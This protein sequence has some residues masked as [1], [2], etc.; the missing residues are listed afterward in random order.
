MPRTVCRHAARSAAFVLVLSVVVGCDRP[1]PPAAKPPELPKPNEPSAAEKPTTNPRARRSVL[2]AFDLDPKPLAFL[3]LTGQLDG[4]LEPC[5]C[6][7]GQKG[8]LARRLDLIGRLEKRGTPI[9]KFDLGSLIQI[10]ANARGG[11]EE[12]KIKFGVAIKAL[13][14]M[15]YDAL[16]LSATDLKVGVDNALG[17]FVNHGERPKV[18]AANVFAEGN[19]DKVFAKS[20]RLTAGPLKIGVVGVL[21]PAAL[22]ILRDDPGKASLTVKEPLEVLGGILKDLEKDTDFQVLLV[23]ERPPDSL[24]LPSKAPKKAEAFAKAFPGFDIVVATSDVPDPEKEPLKLNDGKTL[25]IQVGRKGEYAG[26]V[27]LSQDKKEPIRYRLVE[28]DTTFDKTTEAMRALVDEEFQQ[29]LKNARVVENFTRHAFMQG[30]DRSE[31]VGAGTCKECHPKT[32]FKWV[33]TKHARAYD[34]LIANPKRDRRY[35]AECISCHTTG[36][37]YET[38][39]RSEESSA[40][41]KGNQCENCHGAGSSHSREPDNLAFRKKPLALTAEWADKSRLCLRCHDEDNS[42]DF[43]FEKYYPQIQH[44]GLDTYDDPKVH[45][46]IVAGK[47]AAKP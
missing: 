47:T 14:I 38:G 37:E 26:L 32:Y 6:S 31:F 23:Q 15:E 4:H 18:L 24:A 17:E 11:E 7:E 2:T 5:G 22:E 45:R 46:G 19:L 12:E 41:L 8:G 35:D 36:F 34:S 39:F 29:S 20:L 10:P 9:F 27:G 21:D 30:A 40:H 44:K 28:L 3:L 16:A 33:S 42:P 43:K 1:K 25:M 13:K